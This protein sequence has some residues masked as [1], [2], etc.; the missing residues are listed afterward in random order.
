MD[1]LGLPPRPAF[2]PPGFGTVGHREFVEIDVAPPVPYT[3]ITV[4]WY[5]LAGVA[6]GLLIRASVLA[7]RRYRKDVYRRRALRELAELRALLGTERERALHAVPGLLKRC[8][9]AVFPRE[10][11]AALSGAPWIDFLEQKA[12]SVLSSNSKQALITLVTGSAS[13]LPASVDAKLLEDVARWVQ[14]HRV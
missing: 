9:L 8:A 14:R 1:D 3:P 5:L 11:V 10:R 12:P 4:G 2:L 6:V 13:A 7:V